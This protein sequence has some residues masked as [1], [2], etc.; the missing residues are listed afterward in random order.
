MKNICPHLQG[1]TALVC[2]AHPAEYVPSV[3][4]L[5]AY[6]ESGKHSFCPY[7]QINIMEEQLRQASQKTDG[8]AM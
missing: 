4:E 7:Y 3:K 8:K 5:K 2:N 1:K 6:C